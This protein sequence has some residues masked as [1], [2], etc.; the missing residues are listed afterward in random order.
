[1]IEKYSEELDQKFSNKEELLDFLRQKLKGLALQIEQ[2]SITLEDKKLFTRYNE[3]KDELKNYKQEKN[4]L[5]TLND[6]IFRLK[7]KMDIMIIKGQEAEKV[8][9][10]EKKL[11]DKIYSIK[12]D[13]KYFAR[14]PKIVSSSVTVALSILMTLKTDFFKGT[15]FG[16]IIANFDQQLVG[17]IWLFMIFLTI[18]LFIFLKWKESYIYSVLK[19]LELSSFREKIFREFVIMSIDFYEFDEHNSDYANVSLYKDEIISFFQK[20]LTSPMKRKLLY[21]SSVDLTIAIEESVEIVVAKM[22]ENGILS[23]H[24]KGLSTFYKLNKIE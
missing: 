14:G 22:K 12:E 7:E 11:D 9:A 6:E 15:F 16:E 3:I 1:M 20:R 18:L 13:V 4:D 17:A 2:N 10:Y 8:V 21:N 5:I 23:E 24:V 19:N